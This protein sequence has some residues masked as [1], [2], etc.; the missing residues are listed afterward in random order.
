[1]NCKVIILITVKNL[2][3]VGE[4]INKIKSYHVKNLVLFRVSGAHGT[5]D[6]NVWYWSVPAD[7]VG[8]SQGDRQTDF[9]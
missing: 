9:R 2:R 5:V 6:G 3:H 4:P 7:A 1:M 8:R